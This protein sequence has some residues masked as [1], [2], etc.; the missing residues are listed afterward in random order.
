[1]MNSIHHTICLR[2]LPFMQSQEEAADLRD[3]LLEF[4]AEQ[5][6]GLGPCASVRYTLHYLVAHLVSRTV[7][8]S[9]VH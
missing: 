9:R 4:A 3:H 6:S 2:H 7:D 8:M 5:P 1:M